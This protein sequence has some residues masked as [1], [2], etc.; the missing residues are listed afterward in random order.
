MHVVLGRVLEQDDARR[1]LEVGLDELEDRALAREVGLPL[2]E[3]LL[4]V[5]EAAQRVELVLLVPVEGGLVPHALP[6]RVGVGVDLGVVRVVVD[7]ALVDQR[8]GVPLVGAVRVRARR[9]APQN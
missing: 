7:V 6:D 8:H 2:D 4:D 5:V 9:S 3:G 1:Q